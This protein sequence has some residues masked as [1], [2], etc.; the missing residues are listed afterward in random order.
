MRRM[1]AGPPPRKCGRTV[2]ERNFRHAVSWANAYVFTEVEQVIDEFLGERTT[3]ETTFLMSNDKSEA[4]IIFKLG[5]IGVAGGTHYRIGW[6][7]IETDS[8]WCFEY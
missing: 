8:F 5:T 1:V 6:K 7:K 4:N 2:T 3:F